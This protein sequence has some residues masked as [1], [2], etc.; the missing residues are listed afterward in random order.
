MQE[1]TWY[2]VA[3]ATRARVFKRAGADAAL[4]ELYDFMHPQSQLNNSE[5]SKGETGDS[6]E[7]V[8][9]RKLDANPKINPK[10]KHAESF[11][12]EL[13]TFL[14]DARA[15]DAYGEL[16]LIAEPKVL[17]RL[18]DNL[19]KATEQSV[20]RRIDKNWAQHDRRKIESLLAD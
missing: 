13:A 8:S 6:A 16:V 18:R 5:P 9:R 20:A 15:D 7:R 14:R 19:D 10:G 4:V 12:K 11:T 3:D 17:G 2:V 1:P